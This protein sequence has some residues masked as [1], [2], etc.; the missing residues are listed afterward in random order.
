MARTGVFSKM[1]TFLWQFA[2]LLSPMPTTEKLSLTSGEAEAD[3]PEDWRSLSYRWMGGDS[4]LEARFGHRLSSELDWTE[5]IEE[6]LPTEALEAAMDQGSLSWKDIGE[7]VI[8]RRTFSHRKEKGQPLTSEESDRLVRLL[9]AVAKAKETFQNEEKAERWLRK[10]NRA[11]GGRTPLEVL[12]TESG[13]RL[14][15]NVLGRIGHG[16]YS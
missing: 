15:E 14:V 1:H 12:K 16:V 8:P 13:A 10:E 7:L 4:V 9:R 5:A 6:G 2:H 3:R 11:L